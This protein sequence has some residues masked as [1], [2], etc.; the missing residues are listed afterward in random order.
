[1]AD[2]DTLDVEHQALKEQVEQL[3]REHEGLRQ[4]PHDIAGHEEHRKKLES[5]I[6]ELR[7]HLARLKDLP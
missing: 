4:R 2:R 6:A 7:A 5:K 1:M 3:Q